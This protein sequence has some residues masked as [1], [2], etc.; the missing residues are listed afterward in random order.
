M[1]DSLRLDFRYALRSI[2]KNPGFTA[3]V[4][5]IL[6]LGVGANA[7]I[8]S[9]VDAVVL[10]PL[11]GKD[12]R[13]LVRI[14]STENQGG[15]EQGLT[16]YPIFREYRESLS[17]FSGM[18][19]YRPVSL[20]VAQGNEIGDRV[21]G[22]IAS[23]NLFDVLGVTPLYGRLF[24]ASDDT[25][26]GA[27][28][29]AVLSERYW[30]QQFDARPDVIGSILRINGQPFAIVG[31]APASLQEFERGAEI[32]LPMSMAIQAE[33]MLATQIDRMG[34]DFLKFVGRVKS[35]ISPQQAQS[36][37]NIVSARLG[38]GKTLHLWEGMEG[39][40][41][42]PATPPADASA[43]EQ[44]EW[45]RPWAALAPLQK[46]F[47]PD[48][49]RLSW[50]LLGVAALVL[51]IATADVAGLLL[52]HSENEEREQAIRGSLGASRWALLRLQLVRGLLVAAM[53]S[54]AGLLTASWAAKLLFASA[55]EGLPL[56]VSI[57]SSIVSVRVAVFVIGI[58]CLS[59]IAFSVLPAL[60]RRHAEVSEKLKLQASGSR[61]RPSGG[62]RLHVSLVF[63]QIVASMVLLVGAGLLLQTM[64]NVARIDLGFDTDHVLSASLDL[65]RMG[66]TKPQGATM[67]R[68]LLQ[69]ARAVPGVRSAAL[70]AGSPVTWISGAAKLHSS[71]CNNLAISIVSPGYF[72]TLQIP[73]L[74]G[75]DF[76]AADEKNA[77]GVVILN[78]A[79]VNLCWPS[80]NP[81]GKSIPYVKTLAKPF[82]IVG[83]VGNIRVDELNENPRPQMYVPLAQFYEAFPW[84]LSL[85]ILLRTDAS[86]HA[87]ISALNAGVHSLDANLSLYDVQTPRELLG[88]AFARQQ[89]FTR[90][91]TAFGSLAFVLAIAGLYGLLAYNTAKRT[92]E[93]G[94]RMALGALPRQILQLVLWQGGWLTAVGIFA[95]LAA[96][97]GATHLLQGVLF[98]VSPLDRRVFL[99]AGA[100]FLA[101]GLL[102]CLVPARRATS[103]DPMKALRDE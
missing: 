43:R 57:V 76:T 82:E 102:A 56:P 68:P 61:P 95:G 7:A 81:I 54:V 35:G 50:L 48:E 20:Q 36:E 41:V 63:G 85:S 45:K 2:R 67:V 101:T 74:R 21:S 58:S 52:A 10:Q 71:V 69:T 53:G 83:V 75:R 24:S 33:P 72:D 25:Q 51:I 73:L 22:E 55:P 70:V 5:L 44:R 84:Q 29:V 100:V 94:I 49:S 28:P 87:L 42:N 23:G 47:T 6:A 65:S 27:N 97:I 18:A 8:Y 12:P 4:V 1:L 91:L 32:W 62:S 3:V 98:G 90:I 31:V 38:A 16:S 39:E 37:L 88:R 26:R 77:A 11:P 78:Q 66:Y 46:G 9:V 89:F 40:L 93:F 30:K 19:A 99:A 92:K 17:S 60:K 96:A 103:L 59:G 86:P 14:Y 64:R 13:N 80:Q 79:A 34:N 15:A